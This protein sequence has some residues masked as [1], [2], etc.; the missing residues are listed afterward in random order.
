MVDGTATDKG[1]YNDSLVKCSFQDDNIANADIGT[2][3]KP[4]I[5][6]S[7]DDTTPDPMGIE[8]GEID[9]GDATCTD[10]ADTDHTF[11][12]GWGLCYS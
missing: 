6:T 2:F 10:A 11:I 8:D 12:M 1:A 9:Y 4:D 5:L 3:F 7:S